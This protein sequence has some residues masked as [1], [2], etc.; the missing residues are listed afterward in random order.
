MPFLCLL[1]LVSLAASCDSPDFDRAAGEL[2]RLMSEGKFEEVRTGFTPTMRQ[3]L[4]AEALAQ[5]WQGLEA[6][7]G[8]YGGTERPRAEATPEY[9]IRFVPC[10]FGQARFEFKIVFDRSGKVAG[11]FVQPA[12]SPAASL[13]QGLREI[14]LALANGGFTLPGTL[15]LPSGDGPFPAAVLVHGSGPND[16]DETVGPN[17]PFR[18]LAYGLASRGIAVWRYDKRTKVYGAG[19]FTGPMTVA[20]ETVLDAVAAVREI[21]GRPDIDPR[22]VFV[23]GH[24]LGGYLL[25]RIATAAGARGYIG[26]AAPVT[27]L[28]ELVA[29]QYAYL[30]ALDGSIAAEEAAAVEAARLAAALARSPELGPDTDPARL[31]LGIAASYWLDLKDYHPAEVAAGLSS[32][33][34]FLQGGRDYQVPPGELELWKQALGGRASYRL[35]PELNHLFIAGEGAPTNAEYM[36]PGRVDERVFDDIAAWIR[37]LEPAP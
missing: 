27:S 5:V 35:Y 18:D 23:V 37:S 24:S 10:A 31:P 2:V 17:A 22:R 20:E 15:T 6:Q 16:R 7:A 21:Q 13:P 4:S 29:H 12:A 8:T 28:P 30:S 26:L 11:L 36:R 34:L 19:A 3:A 1:A 25:P 32:P 9:E 14:P 33:F